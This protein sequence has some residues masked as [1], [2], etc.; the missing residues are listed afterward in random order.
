VR[1]QLDAFALALVLYAVFPTHLVSAR[2]NVARIE[3]GEY[4]PVL[5]M[6]RQSQQPESAAELLPLLAHKDARVRQGVATLLESEQKTLAADVGKQGSWRERDVA[7]R[8]TLAKLDAAGPQISAILGTR[9]SPRRAPRAPRDLARRRRG[10]LARGD[11][12]RARRRRGDAQ[13]QRRYANAQ[14]RLLSAASA[15]SFLKNAHDTFTAWSQI[16]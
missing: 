1:R 9:G 13:H 6:F 8:R 7:S 10:S 11:P 12:R 2:V 14:R 5:H 4:A 3:G 15:H 16:G